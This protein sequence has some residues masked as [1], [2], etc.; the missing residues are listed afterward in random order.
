MFRRKTEKPPDTSPPVT[1]PHRFPLRWMKAGETSI[2]S[3]WSKIPFRSPLLHQSAKSVSTPNLTKGQMSRLT[4]ADSV[5][6]VQLIFYYWSVQL[7]KAF[8]LNQVFW[9]LL[10][11]KMV[12]RILASYYAK[13]FSKGFDVWVGE[14]VGTNFSV[15]L[16]SIP[17]WTMMERNQLNLNAHF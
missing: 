1:S 9:V 10:S 13:N 4:I 3:Q 12:L 16:K 14:V 5:R 6:S 2:V 7:R 8:D 11:R 17:G 15:Q